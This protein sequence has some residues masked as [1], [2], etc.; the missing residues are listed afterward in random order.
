MK[1][2]TM[3]N[4][5]A[6]EGAVVKTLPIG[7]V[8][9]P[10]LTVGQDGRGRKLGFILV[11]LLP[12][13]QEELARNGRTTITDCRI[14]ETPRRIISCGPSADDKVLC[15]LRTHI[16]FRGSNYHT[17]DWDPEKEDYLPFPGEVIAW[18][19]IAQGDAGRMG[20]GEQLLAV[21]PKGV[22]FRTAYT[23][24]LYGEPEEH[25]WCFDGETILSLTRD[26]REATCIF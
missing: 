25:F 19:R 15:V 17:G 3:Q 18:G 1:V 9:R 26:E 8:D 16:G 4:G 20:S 10:V 6:T 23:G 7:G 5:R 2:F 14:N 24:R 13:Q 21:I 22:V 12:E 11:Q